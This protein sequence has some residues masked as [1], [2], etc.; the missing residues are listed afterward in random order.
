LKQEIS[1]QQARGGSLIRAYRRT[2]REGKGVE[3]I[4]TSQNERRKSE[5][6][7]GA[8]GIVAGLVFLILA[9]FRAED[10]QALGAWGQAIYSPLAFGSIGLLLLM[11]GGGTM[12]FAFTY[13][14]TKLGNT[15][16]SPISETSEVAFSRDA[17]APDGTRRVE[18]LGSRI[19]A[20]AF[21]QSLVLVVLYAG[22]VQEYESNLTMQSWVRSNLPVGQSVLNW[23]AVLIFSV[24]LGLLLLQFLPKRYLSE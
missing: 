22:F 24:A 2:G 14:E 5:A 17:E 7:A 19:G 9:G 20:V 4:F 12:I 23:E 15:I 6:L 3:A 10:P 18:G 8:A 16:D 1:M 11:C 13:H 21:V